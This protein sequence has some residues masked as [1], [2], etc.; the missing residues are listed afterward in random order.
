MKNK[1]SRRDFLKLASGLALI[2]VLDRSGLSSLFNP[3][4]RSNADQ[5]QPNIIIILQDA[6]SANHLSL[7]G[8]KRQTTPN[9]D[10]FA[11]HAIVYHAHHSASN[12]TTTSTASL[13]T[14]HIPGHIGPCRW[15]ASSTARPRRIT[16]SVS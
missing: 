15:G 16:F 6:F 12:Q 8:Y 1:L 2:P 7:H 3:T 13:F 5:N 9:L 10:R 14:G 4:R 11:E